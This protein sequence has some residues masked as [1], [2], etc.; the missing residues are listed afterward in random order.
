MSDQ[1]EHFRRRPEAL[2]R[3]GF[4]SGSLKGEIFGQQADCRARALAG[5]G[6]SIL[7]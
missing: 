5:K 4:H 3:A 7:R 1:A 2:E 6:R